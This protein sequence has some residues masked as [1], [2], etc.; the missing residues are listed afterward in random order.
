MSPSSET[1]SSVLGAFS[2]A[3]T[4]F[5][6]TPVILRTKETFTM[7]ASPPDIN[8]FIC[9]FNDVRHTRKTAT[10]KK[11]IK[12]ISGPDGEL[13][14]LGT[15]AAG[16]IARTWVV[17]P[18]RYNRGVRSSSIGGG[19]PAYLTGRVERLEI[20]SRS[21][22]YSDPTKSRVCSIDTTTSPYKS[23]ERIGN[24]T[25]VSALGLS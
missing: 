17:V 4:R 22:S 25:L 20:L 15:D 7:T 1:P 18:Y 19:G 12:R 9:S 6:Q 5:A 2:V 14:P 10:I 16:S 13:L 21:S 23:R 11:M 3:T 8:F 24:T